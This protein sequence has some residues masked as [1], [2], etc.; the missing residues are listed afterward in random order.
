MQE[1]DGV[2]DEGPN[3]EQGLMD[4]KDRGARSLWDGVRR[5][6]ANQVDPNARSLPCRCQQ[7]PRSELLENRRETSGEA[8]AETE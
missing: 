2:E 1:F 3:V 8:L 5:C 6:P 4:D 7:R